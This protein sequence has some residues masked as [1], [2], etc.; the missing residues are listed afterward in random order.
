[1]GKG[2]RVRLNKAQQAAENQSVFNAKKQKKQAPAWVGTL[3]VVLVIAL[4]LACVALTV[5]SDGGYTLR[6]TTV[7]ESENYT[8]TGTMLSYFFYQNYSSFLNQY[9][10]VVSYLG[11]NTNLSLKDQESMYGEEEG[12]TWFEYFM[13]PAVE[14][15]KTMLVYCEE[16]NKRGITLDD[17]DYALIDEA[18]EALRQQATEYGYTYNGFISAM[19]GTGVKESDVRAA[20]ELSQLATKCQTQ[21]TEDITASISDEQMTVYYNENSGQFM[22]AGVLSHTFSATE[23]DDAAA[24][25]AAKKDAKETADKLAAVK[26]AEDFKKFVLEQEAEDSY[27]SIYDEQ[28]EDIDPALLPDEAALQA[29]R[30]EIIAAAIANAVEGKGAEETESTDKVEVMFSEIAVELTEEL[31]ATA[32][33]LLNDNF[34]WTDEAEDKAGLWV[35][36]A[37]RA[38]GDVTVIENEGKAD[39]SDEDSKNYYTATVYM[40]TEP[41]RRD[42][43][44]SRNVGHILFTATTYETSAKAEA[45]A[46]E[47]LAE[48]KAGTISREAFEELAKEYTE[49]SGVFY[50]KV[51]PGQMVVEFEDWL[52]DAERKEGDTG[53]VSTQ[54]GYHIMYYLGENADMPAWKVAVQATMVNEQMEEWFTQSEEAVGITFNEDKVNK[55]NA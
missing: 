26:T 2:N 44:L 10:S 28:S 20:L 51:I 40:I 7:A 1:M 3:I 35:S 12:T 32:D 15:V 33:G 16:A 41:M 52:F 4:L 50:D 39:E 14:Q 27:D 37:A 49:D 25:E 48:F 6:W 42:E 21:V 34:Q 5:V 45:K 47:V 23:G 55:I 36:D 24:Y 29:R 18:L 54:Y 8:V 38:A 17:E 9:G 19:Y 11:L 43:T 46:E 30:A 22:T 31:V 13:E 53:V